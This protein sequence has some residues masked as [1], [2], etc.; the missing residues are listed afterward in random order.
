MLCPQGCSV[1]SL[2][3][4]PEPRRLFP[5]QSQL[6]L[7]GNAGD[8]VRCPSTHHSTSN[9]KPE[10]GKVLVSQ[11]SWQHRCIPGGCIQPVLATQW[12]H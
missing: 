2:P 9:Q 1:H 10:Q 12:W 6:L 5:S 3:P 11:L 4:T 7:G 8:G